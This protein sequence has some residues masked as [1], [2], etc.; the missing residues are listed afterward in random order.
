MFHGLSYRAIKGVGF[1]VVIE[2]VRVERSFVHFFFGLPLFL[3]E[4]VVLDLG[5]TI[6][7]LQGLV[8]FLTPIAGIGR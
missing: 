3:V 2:F 7:I 6:L 1:F 5:I 8:V 4:V